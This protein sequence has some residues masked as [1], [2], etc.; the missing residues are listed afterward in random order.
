MAAALIVIL[1]LPGQCL[2]KQLVHAHERRMLHRQRR[3]AN[4]WQLER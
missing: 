2:Y 4:E 3:A 1:Q